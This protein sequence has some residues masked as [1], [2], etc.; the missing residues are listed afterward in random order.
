MAANETLVDPKWEERLKPYFVSVAKVLN[1]RRNH[2]PAELFS[3]SLLSDD[4]EQRFTASDK[5]EMDVALDILH[6]LRKQPV[7]SFDKFCDVLLQ[8][9]DSGLHDVVKLLRPNDKSGIGGQNSLQAS[10]PQPTHR[11]LG[12]KTY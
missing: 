1:P 4:E 9:D 11:Q 7:G 8:V 5:S 10:L 2:L 3:A 6:V 12:G